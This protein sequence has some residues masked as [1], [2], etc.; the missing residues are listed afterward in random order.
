MNPRPVLYLDYNATAPVRREAHAAALA[1][2]EAAGNASSVHAP[3]RAARSLIEAA[4][5]NVARLIGADAE[6][7]VFTSGGTEANALA[8]IGA[9]EAGLAR[10]LIV[11]ALEHDSVRETAKLIA[12]RRNVKLIEVGA[13][14]SGTINLAVLQAALEVAPKPALVS[15]MAANNETG[16]L[17]PVARVA[18]M[19]AQAG[20]L[21]H[22]DAVQIAGRLPF[23]GSVC[24]FVTL[25]SHKLGGAQGAGAV[26]LGRGIEVEALWG[27]GAQERRRRPGTENV[28]AIAA[29]GAAALAAAQ[30]ID[31][32]E[33]HAAW[34]DALE[35]RLLD[36]APGLQ[37]FG[38]E[39]PRLPQTSCLGVAGF[40]A[41]TQVIAL[42]LEG[43]AVSAGAACSSGKVSA[44]HVITAMG[45]DEAAARAAIRVSFGWA[46]RR[47][48]VERFAE[49]WSRVIARSR[50]VRK[51]DEI[52]RSEVVR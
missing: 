24:Q 47:D 37:V 40:A 1:A 32:A 12:R 20:A 28:P 26:S 36:A 18:A 35:A 34:R 22:V 48:E 31:R 30:E 25:S 11:F 27:G 17:Q 52:R 21:F 10:S 39:A 2:M 41:E 15:V 3:G 4:R 42:D 51:V 46:T 29:F 14:R 13:H 19:C 6:R 43:A 50:E 16:V 8:L 9:F 7:V 44:S 23:D 38:A 33:E 45:Y 5:E 49:I